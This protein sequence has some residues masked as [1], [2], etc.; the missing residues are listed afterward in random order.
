FALLN[1]AF[2]IDGVSL[3][4]QRGAQRLCIELL[5]YAS[6]SAASYPRTDVRVA[7]GTHLH[8][9]E[10]HLSAP[11]ATSLTN[12]VVNVRLEP[13]ASL[14]H[15][16]L[17]AHGPAS[18]WID[19]LDVEVGEGAAYRLHMA[20]VGA[21]S[22]RTTARVRLAGPRAQ[23]AVHA[24]VVAEGQQTGDSYVRVEHAAPDTRTEEVF[25]GIAAGRA[26]VAFNAHIV[27]MQG[28]RG[29]DS[30]QSLRG[31]LA[32]PQA[33]IDARPQLEIYN[34]DV[35]CSHGATAGKLD[36]AMLFYLLSRG[37]EPDIAQSLLKWAFLEDTVSRI[38]VP[39]WRAEVERVLA[40]HLKDSTVSE[41]LV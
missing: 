12:G 5:H 35:R 4:T 3:T 20:S 26:R 22:A 8:L 27:V 21:H 31:L 28:A 10:R 24:A 9:I 30:R 13:D 36:D 6:G 29:S 15:F 17:Q 11:D 18:S 37:I 19:S 38:D 14:S 34:D 7:R 16:R 32:G 23:V 1:E 41:G 25:R 33:E 39:A 2:A 40:A